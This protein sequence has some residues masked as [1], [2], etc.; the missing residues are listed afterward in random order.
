MES[1]NNRRYL[2][3]LEIQKRLFFAKNYNHWLFQEIQEYL[4]DN[5]LEVGCAIGNFTQKIINRKRVCVVDIESN[6][7]N[8]ANSNF[9]NYHNFQAIKCDISSCD[10]SRQLPEGFDTVICLNVLEHVENEKAALG[11]MYNLLKE[12]GYLCLLVPAFNCIFGEMDKTDGHFKRYEKSA[13]NKALQESGFRILKSKYI[14]F[15]GF[16][17]WWFNGR[18]LKRKYI[19]FFQM[20]MY[21]FI[22]PLVSLMERIFNPPFGQSLIVIAKK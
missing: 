13:L 21:D 3:S 12:G 22:V 16:F 5:L 9:K 18:I 4:G 19:P 15:L 11:N 20:L 2:N 10:I 1:K 14:N 6:Y 17:G 8:R 7:I